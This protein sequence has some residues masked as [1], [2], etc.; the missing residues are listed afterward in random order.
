LPVALPR[1]PLLPA[2][3]VARRTGL[4]VAVALHAGLI[5]AAL[6]Y[7]PARPARGAP[8]AIA[9]EWIAAPR[10]E[11][12]PVME[13]KPVRVE[14]PKPVKRA[15]PKRSEP[16]PVAA[17]PPPAPAEPA[18]EPAPPPPPP[19]APAPMAAVEPSPAPPPVIVTP[20]LFNADYLANPAPPYPALSRRTGEQGRVILRVHVTPGGTVD[21]I[22]V[23]TSSGHAR[24]DDSALETVKRWK[25]VPARQGAQ[26]IAAWVL[27]PISF[28]LDS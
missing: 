17:A 10:V 11:A 21:D 8:A 23:R 9:V 22:Q 28:G 7:E 18:A 13:P 16:S 4:A 12:P 2:P 6:A 20:P 19:A 1:T 15:A 24:L 5:A 27:V 3:R 26:P 14:R 25:F